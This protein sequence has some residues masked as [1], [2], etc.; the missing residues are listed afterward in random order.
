M[1]ETTKREVDFDRESVDA[2]K[3]LRALHMHLDLTL[4]EIEEP[5]GYKYYEFETS[6]KQGEKK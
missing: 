1:R 4:I 6:E 2:E 5:S 3:I